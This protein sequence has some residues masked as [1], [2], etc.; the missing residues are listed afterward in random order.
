VFSLVYDEKFGVVLKA[1]WPDVSAAEYDKQ[2]SA[3]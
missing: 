3:A 2:L 1:L